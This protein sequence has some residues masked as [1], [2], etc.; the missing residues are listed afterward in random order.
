MK[1]ALGILAVVAMLP[2]AYAQ[3][4]IIYPAKGQKPEQQ[5]KD[6]F[7]C[8]QWAAQQ[9]GFDPMQ[10]ANTTAPV[11][12]P[13]AATSQSATQQDATKPRGG[14]LKG[15]GAGAA[16]GAI[17]G[18]DVG[19][20]AV[21]GAVIGGVAQRSK[22]RGIEAQKQAQQQSAPS[23]VAQPSSAQENYARARAACLEGRG[24]SVK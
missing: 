5:K 24:Y 23:A 20:A 1:K 22:R 12:A 19:E 9:S 6:E 21:K 17:G 10:A 4:V 15:A 11:A 13:P 18:N 3:Q 2:M 16:V 14:L 8:Y 7:E